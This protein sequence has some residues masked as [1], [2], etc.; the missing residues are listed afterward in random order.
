[1]VYNLDN[2]LIS[3]GNVKYCMVWNLDTGK[4]IAPHSPVW[5]LDAGLSY[6]TNRKKQENYIV[7]PLQLSNIAYVV[8]DHK[9][10]PYNKI[11]KQLFTKETG[12]S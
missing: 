6:V 2:I 11:S 1:M 4:V 3:L 7:V 10:V 5:T 8:V 9:L 12:D